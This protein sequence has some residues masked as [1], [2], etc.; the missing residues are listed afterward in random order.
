MITGN[1]FH[2]FL[3]PKEV[4]G[5]RYA[6]EVRIE[7]GEI[8]ASNVDETCVQS[9]GMP[10]VFFVY[11][12]LTEDIEIYDGTTRE[13]I[14]FFYSQRSVMTQL[15]YR[16]YFNSISAPTAFMIK[17]LV[18]RFDELGSMADCPGRGVHRNIRTEGNVETVRQSAAED[19]SVSTRRHSSQLGISKTTFL[20]I[21]K[22]NLKTCPEAWKKKCKK[23]GS[24][25][26]RKYIQ[27]NM[28]IP[29]VPVQEMFYYR[30]SWLY[31]FEIH[32]L[33]S[34]TGYFYTYH[35]GQA[36]KGLNEVCNF[37]DDYIKKMP[38]EIQELYIFS[39]S[40]SEQNHN[41]PVV[42]FFLYHVQSKRFREIVQYF[43]I[44]G[45]S[46]LP[47]DRDFGRVK[48]VMIEYVYQKI[49]RA[50]NLKQAQIKTFHIIS[51][52]IDRCYRR[53]KL[54]SKRTMIYTKKYDGEIFRGTRKRGSE[55]NVKRSPKVTARHEVISRHVRD[56]SAHENTVEL[57]V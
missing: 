25:S 37:I 17:S 55:I 45:H 20:R 56:E 30:Q 57:R 16:Q 48:Q 54:V 50:H 41:H 13:K 4:N 52:K 10:F 19:S 33:K 51:D 7:R 23:T 40:C 8:I 53:Q 32:D 15:K 11:K 31:E 47:C 26:W 49:M 2:L 43:P 9:I 27:N 46:F 3:M 42:K 5:A 38:V 12:V 18:G 35:E 39:D 34:D 36:S 14:E 22:L 29:V 6:P 24:S 44:R 1:I 28:P 21:L